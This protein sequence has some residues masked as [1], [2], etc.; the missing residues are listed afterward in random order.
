VCIQFIPREKNND[1]VEIDVSFSMVYE[2]PKDI[3]KQLE[4]SCYDCHSNSTN[5]PWYSKIQPV[6]MLIN[7]HVYN[8]KE[9]LNFDSFGDYS[10]RKRRGKLKSIINQIK[11]NEM[12]LKSYEVLH[13]EAKIDLKM[14]NKIIDWIESVD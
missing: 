9:E 13:G 6:N 11:D 12:P 1:Y 5:Y 3:E 8:G 7:N 14:K 4:I 2:I 10:N